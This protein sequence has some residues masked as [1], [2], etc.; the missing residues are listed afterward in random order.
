VSAIASLQYIFRPE[1]RLKF[2]VIVIS[3]VVLRLILDVVRVNGSAPEWF[4]LIVDVLL[5]LLINGYFIQ[6]LRY[7]FSG[8]QQLPYP[9]PA[10]LVRGIEL[11]G[12]WFLYGMMV[13]VPI[14][15]LAVVYD[16][17]SPP[18]I[19][20]LL[21]CTPLWCWMFYAMQIGWMKLA[22][23]QGL[24]G[25][26]NLEANASAI[27]NNKGKTFSLFVTQL[28]ML[29]TLTGFYL[30]IQFLLYAILSPQYQ[31]I[32]LS[33]FG[34]YDWVSWILLR[35]VMPLTWI[36]IVISTHLSLLADY[37]YQ[38][39]LVETVE[40]AKIADPNPITEL[41]QTLSAYKRVY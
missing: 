1:N 8:N 29:I 5:I 19:G 6:I 26:L 3:W 28:G 40:T 15:I 13:A 31:M 36:A 41:D 25:L 16:I 18:M 33:R 30:G 32:E 35:H 24:G 7:M 9:L 39:G 34:V 2:V 10:D 4:L 21:I 22:N 20:L 23:G 27:W 37:A 38:I 11:L 12:A 17:N 14:F